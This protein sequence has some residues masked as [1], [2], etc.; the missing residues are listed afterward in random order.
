MKISRCV[1][2]VER[3]WTISLGWEELMQLTAAVRCAYIE[4]DHCESYGTLLRDLKQGRLAF[5]F[6]EEEV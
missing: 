2:L 1:G 4:S 3:P 5:E 6:L